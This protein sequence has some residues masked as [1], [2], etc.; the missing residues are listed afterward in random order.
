[1]GKQGHWYF[2]KNFVVS[3]VHFGSMDILAIPTLSIYEYR[4][5]FH[6]FDFTL[7]Y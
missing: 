4:M 2:D 6:L 5:S 3:M 7:F 1:M